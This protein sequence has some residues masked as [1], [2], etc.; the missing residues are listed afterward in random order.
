MSLWQMIF[1]GKN[2]SFFLRKTKRKNI[3]PI[4]QFDADT[5]RLNESG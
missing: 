5:G 3:I 1:L 4:S 2:K